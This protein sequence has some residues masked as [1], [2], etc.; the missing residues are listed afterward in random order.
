[1]SDQRRLTNVVLRLALLFPLPSLPLA[2]APCVDADGDTYAQCPAGCQLQ[3]QQTCGD[4]KDFDPTI[5]PGA[6]D[7][8]CDGINQ[9]CDMNDGLPP[10]GRVSGLIF[11]ADKQSL[12]WAPV[13][14][15]QVYDVV[16]GDL[17]ALRSSGGDFLLTLLGCLENRSQ[18]TSSS[19][20][21]IPPLGSGIYYLARHHDSCDN[22]GTFNSGSPSQVGNRD[23]EI[24]ENFNA[25]VGAQC[26]AE[27]PATGH[28]TSNEA[29]FPAVCIPASH[30]GFC[31]SS[32]CYCALTGQGGAG[33]R[34]TNDCL[35]VCSSL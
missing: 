27:N 3:P 21:A 24:D 32:A 15:A 31:T 5:H 9:D 13:A 7:V 10:T 23:A 33:W 29:C 12:T 2:A 19:D 35:G 6:L 1:M 26:V 18:D 11:G 28:C 22:R 4:C 17:G 34:C 8:T 30:S 25:C 14:G 20:A 16:R